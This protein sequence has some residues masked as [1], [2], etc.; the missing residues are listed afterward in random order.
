MNEG[1]QFWK[2]RSKHGRDKL[3]TTPE[4]LWE[5]ACEYFDWCDKHPWTVR[6]AVQKNIP[7]RVKVGKKTVTETEQQ[8]E[9]HAAPVP[10]AYSLSGFCLYVGATEQWWYSFKN[11]CVK[12]GD[13]DFLEV[14]SRIQEVMRTQQYE[15]AAAGVFNANIMAR[16]LGLAD[17][18]LVA[19]GVGE[20][21]AGKRYAGM[22][23]ADVIVKVASVL[24]DAEHLA[25]GKGEGKEEGDACTEEGQ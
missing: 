18:Q 22:L 3:F 10:R 14:M 15:G 24:Q 9:Q 21:D 16:M 20:G 4:L 7:K 2:L 1:N 6:K 13:N 19:Y 23:S 11:D 25:L 12:K 5:A 17:R 8:T